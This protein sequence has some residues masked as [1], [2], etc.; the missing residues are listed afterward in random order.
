MTSRPNKC[1]QP[2][3]CLVASGSGS[4]LWMIWTSVPAR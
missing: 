1:G 2:W 3:A 4:P